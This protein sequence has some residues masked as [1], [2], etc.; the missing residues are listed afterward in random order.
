MTGKKQVNLEITGMDCTS[1]ALLI[2]RSLRKIPGVTEANVN[3]ATEKARVI[4]ENQVLAGQLVEA[5][6]K[7]GYGAKIEIAGSGAERE[8]GKETEIREYKK[9]FIW[10]GILSAPIMMLPP[11]LGWILATPVQF[12]LGRR[13]YRGAWSALA[14]KVF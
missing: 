10:A 14:V 2:Q 9:R 4:A 8:I 7:A 12:I 13:F 5:V 1:C 6:E 11:F 3:Y